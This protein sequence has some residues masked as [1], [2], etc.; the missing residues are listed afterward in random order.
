MKIF[1]CRSSR[2]DAYAAMVRIGFRNCCRQATMARAAID[3]Y[4][5]TYSDAP[6]RTSL[7]EVAAIPWPGQGTP[8]V[9]QEG[10]EL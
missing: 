4:H 3:H 5:R 9:G 10:R 8:G 7:I 6:V 2:E 1:V